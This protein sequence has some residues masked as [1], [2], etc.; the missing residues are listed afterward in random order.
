MHRLGYERYGAHGGDIG[1]GISGDLGIHDPDRVVG[2]HVSTDPT[3]LALIGGMLPDETE[4]MTEAQKGRLESCEAG[5]PTAGATSR[6]SPPGR[7]RWRADQ[8]PR[9][10][11]SSRIVEKFKEWTNPG[12]APRRRRRSGAAAHRRQHLLVHGHGSVT[13][14]SSTRLPTPIAIGSDASA[15]TGMAVFAADN[16]LRPS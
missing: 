13:H 6:S 4:D 15:P 2:A 11:R 9:P 12:R 10:R 14:T 3:A 5:R 7:G 8:R 1:A 16:L